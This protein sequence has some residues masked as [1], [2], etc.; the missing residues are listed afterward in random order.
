MIQQL[1]TFGS[2][3]NGP[4]SQ[5]TASDFD[6]EHPRYRK[7]YRRAAGTSETAIDQDRPLP[8][9]TRDESQ[10]IAA[11]PAESW[12][13]LGMQKWEGRVVDVADGILTAELTAVGHEGPVL[14]ADFDVEL[15][16]PEDAVQP[17]DIVYLTVRTVPDGSRRKTMTSVLRLR[18]LGRWTDEELET[19]KATARKKLGL[20]EKYVD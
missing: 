14:L 2:E 9:E 15:L 3:T 4:R 7:D 16:E 11:R 17:G 10:T 12:P 6:I 5:E 20:I 13:I 1:S 8:D 18:R 19:A